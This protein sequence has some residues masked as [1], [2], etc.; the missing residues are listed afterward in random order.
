MLFEGGFAPRLH[1]GN[2][3]LGARYAVGRAQC[4]PLQWSKV[5][6]STVTVHS[7]ITVYCPLLLFTVHHIPRRRGF[8]DKFVTGFMQ[9]SHSRLVFYFSIGTVNGVLAA[10]A[11]AA[12]FNAGRR[13]VA[14]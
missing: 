13:D 4:P 5:L 14:V 12:T 1:E 8:N 2:G 7:L 6:Q 3:C 11:V 9:L 10:F